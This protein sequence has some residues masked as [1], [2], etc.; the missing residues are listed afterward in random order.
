MTLPILTS[1]YKQPRVLFE[2]HKIGFRVNKKHIKR[3]YVAP[4]N[5]SLLRIQYICVLIYKPVYLQN[6]ISFGI[7]QVAAQPR[8]N[9]TTFD[10]LR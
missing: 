6:I 8:R 2:K 3:L 4:N 1:E 7:E 5:L 9:G 10:W